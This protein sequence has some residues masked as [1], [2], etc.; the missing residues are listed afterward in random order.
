MFFVLSK[1]LWALVEPGNFLVAMLTVGAV[2]Q[3]SSRR[4][5]L[6][7]W[8]VAVAT[9]GFLAIMLTPLSSL[10]AL[11]LEDR[12]PPPTT[13]P[14]HVDGVI[15]LGGGVEPP[16]TA[17]R[18]LPTVSRAGGRLIA[19]ADLVRRFP[20]A[21]HIYSGGSGLLLAQELREDTAARGA[22]A[23]MGIDPAQVIFENDSRNTWEN[24][25]FSQRIVRPK[26]GEV[27]LLVTSAL[28]MPRSVGIFRQI[29]WP[30]VPYPV[31]FRTLAGGRPY[32]RYEF[33]M[34]IELLH[35][36]IREWIGL[37]AY[38]LM[39]RADSLFPGP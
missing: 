27:W 2:L 29:G 3:F 12:F 32:L 20:D 30:V 16:L 18:G 22:L 31:D 39:G 7:R 37:V 1:V 36:A 11:P 4:A 26:P 25:L 8:L 5:R 28:H 13:I 15:V 14:A 9:V 34:Q 21:T 24:A 35:D 10:V 6:G 33:D 17:D 23:Q 19:F 38:R